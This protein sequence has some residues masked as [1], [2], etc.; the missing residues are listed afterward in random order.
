MLIDRSVIYREEKEVENP[1]DA[2]W[3]GDSNLIYP[4]VWEKQLS[5]LENSLS[6][7]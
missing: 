5:S 3:D 1:K 7:E 6:N 2:S 4:D